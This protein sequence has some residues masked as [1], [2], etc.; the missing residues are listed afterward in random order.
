MR[1]L[2]INQEIVFYK[3]YI[4]ETETTDSYGYKTGNFEST[5]SELKHAL[6]CVSPNKGSNESELFGKMLDYDR[7]M[8]TA[9]T[10]TDIDENTV[11]WLDGKD[12]EE[13]YNYIV[14]KRAMWKN[15][16]LF[17]VREVKVSDE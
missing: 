5:Y 13:E 4:G 16:V 14:V 1:D 9:D 3:T 11:L 7:T 10:E 8:T 6:L 12:T 15:S 2:K 17:A